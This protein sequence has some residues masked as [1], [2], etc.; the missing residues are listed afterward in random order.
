M[1]N[2]IVSLAEHAYEEEAAEQMPEAVRRLAR[3][4][5]SAPILAEV[6]R[7]ATRWFGHLVS[8]MGRLKNTP[9]GGM[10]VPGVLVSL[11]HEVSSLPGLKDSGLPGM[12]DQL[13]EAKESTYVAKIPLARPPQSKRFPCC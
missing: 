8:D 9:G 12:V 2:W 4:A 6:A 7:C 10:G 13:H 3:L 1:L 5:A 11:L